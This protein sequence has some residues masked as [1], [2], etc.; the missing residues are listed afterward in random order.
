MAMTRVGAVLVGVTLL[1][2]AAAGCSTKPSE[3]ACEKAVSNIRKLTKQSNTEIG[4]DKRAA[5]RSCRAQSSK[6]TVECMAE[7]RT[8]EELFACGGKMAEQLKKAMEAQA[9]EAPATGD[10]KAPP[11]PPASG[12]PPK[13]P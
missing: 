4:A 9:K 5:I 1:L 11:P 7:A 2:G 13:G 10:G 3:E 12:D 6:D 8:A